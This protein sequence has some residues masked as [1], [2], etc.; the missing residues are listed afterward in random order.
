MSE[1]RFPPPWTVETIP[2]GLKVCD[3]NGQSLAYVYSRENP[4]DAHM[5]KVLTKDEARRIAS[6]IAK[7]DV[8]R[9]R[10]LSA[11]ASVIVFALSSGGRATASTIVCG[12][13]L[14][15]RTSTHHRREPRR[16]SPSPGLLLWRQEA[17]PLLKTAGLLSAKGAAGKM[18]R[19]R[20]AP[21]PILLQPAIG[22]AVPK[23][24]D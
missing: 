23:I 12:M 17:R 4:N 16:S 15:L 24:Q 5:A 2:G 1:R 21:P 20:P 22:S 18:E 8:A 11:S 3:A 10:G 9:H 13:I 6:N 14:R 19:L 7:A